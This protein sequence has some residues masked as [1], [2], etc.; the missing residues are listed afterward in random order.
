MSVVKLLFS[1]RWWW[2]T[3]L[4]IAGVGVLARL[5]VWQLDRLEERKAQ[6][7]HLLAMQALQPLDLNLAPETPGM[8]GMEYRLANV[9][10]EYDYESEVVIRNQV[11][12]G[13]PGYAVLTPLKIEGT[14]SVIMVN[15]GWIPADTYDPEELQATLAAYRKEGPV[16]IYG[17]IR[18]SREKPD[19]GGRNDPTP[20]PGEV[21][22]I[23]NLTNLEMISRQYS[24]PVLPVYLQR[25]PE[26]DFPAD[27]NAWPREML[28]FPSLP[29]VEITEGP[30]MGY[31]LQWFAFA[32]ILGAGY[33]V[34]L[35][36]EMR[37]EQAE[38]HTPLKDRA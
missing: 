15:R 4:V 12:N 33:P 13:Q 23:W 5:G 28:P 20:A 29:E 25:G 24:Y 14:S 27:L 26:M 2:T 8:E 9:R 38:L 7:A 36:R 37:R 1:R 34:F 22:L 32:T 19:F 6:N 10:G 16:V 3:L 17:M 21:V 30:H 11:W 35:Y 18:A 31:A